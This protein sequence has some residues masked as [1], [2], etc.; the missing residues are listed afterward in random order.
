MKNVKNKSP[1]P[2]QEKAGNEQKK[3]QDGQAKIIK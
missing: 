3:S 1:Q 2:I